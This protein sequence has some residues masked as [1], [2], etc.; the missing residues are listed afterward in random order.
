MEPRE[1]VREY[2]NRM[3]RAEF[4]SVL[5]LFD[6]DIVL[7]DRFALPEPRELRSKAVALAAIPKN[8]EP[9]PGK[10]VP[11]FYED[12]EVRDLVVHEMAD[13]N[14]VVAEWTYVTRIGDSTVENHNISVVELRDGRIVH[15]REYHNHIMRSVA[16]GTVPA[17]IATI[18]R[19]ILPEDRT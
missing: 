7:C 10:R 9:E 4:D 12:L 6:D 16:E 8:F 17:S 1:I 18:E 14:K 3:S 5:E 13:P 11:R 2:I 15:S 19:M